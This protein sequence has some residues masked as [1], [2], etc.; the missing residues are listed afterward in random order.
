MQVA[1]AWRSPNLIEELRAALNLPVAWRSYLLILG[2]GF[3][4][5]HGT[6]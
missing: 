4:A 1:N 3:D 2:Q 5:D 6:V